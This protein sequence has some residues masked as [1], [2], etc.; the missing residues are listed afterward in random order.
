MKQIVLNI[1]EDKYLFFEV[2]GDLKEEITENLKQGFRELKQY[3]EGK[4]QTTAAKDFLD[5][6]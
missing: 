3:K 1:K 6:L 2:E 4:L 5:E